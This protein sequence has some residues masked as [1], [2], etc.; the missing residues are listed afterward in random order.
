MTAM[1]RPRGGRILLLC[2]LALAL[3]AAAPA[4]AED[5]F[6]DTIPRGPLAAQLVDFV[7]VP[8]SSFFRPLAR[9]N[10]LTHAGDGSGRLFVNDMRGKIWVIDGGVLQPVPFLDVAAALSGTLDIRPLQR[11]VVSLAFHPDYANRASPGF[12]KL[13]LSTSETPRRTDTSRQAWGTS[14]R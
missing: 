6:V 14:S 11:G 5:P 13:Y 12:G 10:G 2:T 7:Q 4:A 3:V 8:A 9:I 1:W